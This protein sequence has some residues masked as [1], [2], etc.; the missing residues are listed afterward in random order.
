MWV[1]WMAAAVAADD[2]IDAR[3][4]AINAC[5]PAVDGCV[6]IVSTAS[7]MTVGPKSADAESRVLDVTIDVRDLKRLKRSDELVLRLAIPRALLPADP[8]PEPPPVEV[9]TTALSA[10]WSTMNLP[11]DGGTILRSDGWSMAVVYADYCAPKRASEFDAAIVAAGWESTFQSDDGGMFSH[12]YSHNEETL[13]FSAM[14]L[15]GRTTL[16]ITRF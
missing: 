7:A 15:A 5:V 6:M 4:E 12:T 8:E 10:P 16:S 13:T 14:E 2:T 9:P 11:I 1:A 3:A